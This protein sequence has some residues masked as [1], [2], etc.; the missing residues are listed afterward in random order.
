[1]PQS[2]QENTQETPQEPTQPT[3]PTQPIPTNTNENLW[4]IL[5]HLAGLLG[6]TAI[7]FANVLGPLVIWLI[8]KDEIPALNAHG[9]AA[10]NF[11]ISMAIYFIAC[12][13]LCIIVIGVFG[14]IALGILNVI[15]I[16]IATVK[17]AD[18]EVY[19]YPLSIKF[20]K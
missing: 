1:M 3:Q 19:D 15:F 2:P 5:C 17:A 13:P 4:P 7:P 18:G 11:Q 10:I 12:I 20:L 8:K 16:I 14:M 9:K 6:Y